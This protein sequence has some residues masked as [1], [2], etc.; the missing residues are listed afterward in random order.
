MTAQ[1]EREMVDDQERGIMGLCMVVAFAVA[2]AL[3]ALFIFTDIL[4]S[5]YNT[6]KVEHGQ[7]TE[8]R[9]T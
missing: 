1:E 2:L 8:N 3:A 5:K 4:A 7:G 9:G 6:P